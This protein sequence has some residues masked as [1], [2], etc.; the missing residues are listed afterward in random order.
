MSTDYRALCA[1]LI[2]DVRYLIDCV[3]HDCCDPVALMECRE[4]VSQT[5]TA[6]AQPQPQ[7]PS[8]EDLIQLAID[9][10]LYRFQATAGDPIQYEMTEQQIHAFA[11]AALARWGRPAIEP[12]LVSERLPGEGDCDAEGRCWLTSVDVEP[13]W[14]ADNPEQCTNWTH[15]LPHHALPLPTPTL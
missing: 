6:L 2:E 3:D 8:D 4:H 9:T 7:G 14:V 5:R 15:W 1:E 12:V 11:R 10:R 13:G